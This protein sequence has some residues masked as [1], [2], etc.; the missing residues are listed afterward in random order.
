MLI[1]FSPEL[2]DFMANL[3]QISLSGGGFQATATR[4][5]RAAAALAAAS[6]S[7]PDEDT[8]PHATAALARQA[9]RTVGDLSMA[10]LARIAHSRILWVDD[11][12]DNNLNERQALEALG[13]RFLLSSTTENALSILAAERFDAIIS[14]MARGGDQRAGYALLDAL[15][16]AGNTTPIIIYASSRLPEHVAEAKAHGAFGCTNQATELFSLVLAALERS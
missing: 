13:V 2:R 15:S 7:W 10:A 14:D 12:P 8:T 11:Q 3:G 16:A 9:V 1:R 6:V 5:N 4:R